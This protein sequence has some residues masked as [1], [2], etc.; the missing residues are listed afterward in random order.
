MCWCFDFSN[1]L[2]RFF[3][4]RDTY[5]STVFQWTLCLAQ[6]AACIWLLRAP[7]AIRT[8]TSSTRLSISSFVGFMPCGSASV[9]FF[10][11]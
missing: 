6:M 5:L 11:L 10:D 1:R 3:V 2:R 7:R 9:T 8:S 4:A